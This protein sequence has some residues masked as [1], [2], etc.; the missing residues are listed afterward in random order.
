MLPIDRDGWPRRC[1][2]R[3]VLRS[4]VAT[5]ASAVVGGCTSGA[6]A[7]DASAAASSPASAPDWHERLAG[8]TLALLG[9][10]HDNGEHHRL[11][12]AAL[13]AA[14]ERGWRPAIV[15][16]QFDL[17]RQRDIDRARAERPADAKHVITQAGGDANWLWVHYEAFVALALQHRLPLLAGNLPRAMV[18]RLA[19]DDYAAVLGAERVSAWRLHESPDAAW[20]AAQEREIDLGHCGALPQRL[21]PAL[22]RAQFARDAAMAHLLTQHASQGAVL[23]AGNGHVRRDLGV[24]RWLQRHGTPAALVVGYIERGTPQ[25]RGRYDEVVVTAATPRGDPCEAFKA[26]PRAAPSNADRT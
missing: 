15:M 18:S 1:T 25:A 16:E 14:I 23:L 21:W 19:R 2:R 24:P 7:H 20:Q 5:A 22:A 26:R 17:D 10:V 9:E 8:P 11:R 12:A 3:W 4:G 13:R 6:P